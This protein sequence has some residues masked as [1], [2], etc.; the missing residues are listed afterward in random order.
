MG[1]NYYLKAK[2]PCPCC[3]REYN[4][5]HIGKSSGGWVF[6]LHIY[7]DEGIHDLPNWIPLLEAEGAVI[8]NEY[9]DQVTVLE[10]L[11]IITGRTRNAD[12]L[13][14]EFLRRNHAVQGPNNLLRSD[15]ENCDGYGAGT[16]DLHA[17][18]FS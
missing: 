18:D 3:G 2:P 10:L 5:R 13:D 14:N 12:Q 1:T 16:W 17:H 11:Q 8:V 15:P 6:A 9:G 7:P 4:D